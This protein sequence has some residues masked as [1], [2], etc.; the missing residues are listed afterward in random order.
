V[1]AS[2]A[3]EPAFGDKGKRTMKRTAIRDVLT[4]MTV[5]GAIAATAACDPA[6]SSPASG[7]S[8]TSQAESE[9][10]A[11]SAPDSG[12]RGSQSAEPEQGTRECW[13]SDVEP[14]PVAERKWD[15][16]GWEGSV[17][18]AN[19]GADTCSLAGSGKVFA[20]L[21]DG[22]WLEL[23][24][25]P[26]DDAP[27]GEVELAPGDRAVLRLRIAFSGEAEDSESCPK[28][29]LLGIGLPGETKALEV[30]PPENRGEL[31][32]ICAKTIA[33]SD[34]VAE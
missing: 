21:P 33:V 11:T 23:K 29:D 19:V 12:S 9:S 28:P 10:V 34:W 4:T 5:A 6:A 13:V 17:V 8:T 15:Q 27:S 1:K 30:S 20:V 7:S 25:T 3:G 31:P 18:V 14:D 32:P 2:H 16:S 24:Q 26:Y 22:Q